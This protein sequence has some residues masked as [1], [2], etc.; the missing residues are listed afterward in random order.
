MVAVQGIVAW[1]REN[2]G[3]VPT[4]EQLVKFVLNLYPTP[5]GQLIKDSV[6]LKQ[7]Q[8]FNKIT[9]SLKVRKKTFDRFRALQVAAVGTDS[10]TDYMATAMFMGAFENLPKGRKWKSTSE[11]QLLRRIYPVPSRTK[12]VLR[13]T[14]T[15]KSMDFLNDL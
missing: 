11:S 13:Y 12:Q 1:F 2:M 14:S 7:Y 4:S 15:T 8:F 3:F 5:S 10:H 6:M 9:G